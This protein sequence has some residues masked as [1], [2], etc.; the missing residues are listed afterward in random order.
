MPLIFFETNF[1]IT[2]DT[3]IIT[4]LAGDVVRVLWRHRDTHYEVMRSEDDRYLYNY[5][6]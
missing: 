1:Y 4:L 6:I 5:K 2:Y 3:L